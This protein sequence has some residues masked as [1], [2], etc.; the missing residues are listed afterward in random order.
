MITVEQDL[1]GALL[2]SFK[3]YPDYIE[4]VKTLNA[5]FDPDTKKWTIPASRL[6]TLKA[7]FPGELFFK[8]PEWVITGDKPPDYSHLYT[9]TNPCKISSLGWNKGVY[10]FKYQEF[11]IQFLVDRLKTYKMAFIADDVGLGKTIQAMGAFKYLFDM[12]EVKDIVVICKKSI[13]YQWQ[14]EIQT[15]LDLDADIYVVDDNKKKREK[16]YED[17]KN[18][19]RKTILILNYHILMNDADLI[20]ADMTI[21]DEVHFAKKYN[22]EINKGCKTLTKKAKYCLFMTGTP[23]MSNPEDMYG[24][25]N[26]KDSKYFGSHKTFK[27]RYIV[28]YYNGRFKTIVGYRN[29]D[30]LR[31]KVQSIILRRTANE[32]SIDLPEVVPIAKYCTLDAKQMGCLEIASAKT[33]ETEKKIAYFKSMLKSGIA[34]TEKQ[35][36]VAEITKAEGALKGFIAVEQA[37]ANT[38]VMFHY[39]KSKGVKAVYKDVTPSPSYLSDKMVRLIELV[40][41]I[42]D[43]G[44]KVVCF[45]KYETVAQYVVDLLARN[46]IKSVMYTG[47]MSDENRNL[48][49]QTFKNDDECVAI[50]GTDAMAEGLNLQIANSLINIDLPFNIATYNQRVGRIRRTKSKYDKAFVYNLITRGSI[51]ENIYNKIKETANTFDAVVSVDAAQSAMLKD[52]SN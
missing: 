14:D 37:I 3:Y 49:V 10:P 23:V 15:F 44:R 13:K 25:V 17:I 6:L 12:G 52:L 50:I 8:T 7:T 22:G 16:A 46:K 41:S 38:P 11:G 4:R 42:S 48:S 51:D 27:D 33:V 35:K 43:A 20:K 45:T 26:I 36:I 34:E 31:D 47:T 1:F 39:S 21:Y 30:E 2:L 18:N 24:I 29:L 5:T 28:E 40:E 9:F 19:P 32:V